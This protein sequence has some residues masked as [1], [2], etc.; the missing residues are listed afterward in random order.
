MS[1]SSQDF[2][3]FQSFDIEEIEASTTDEERSILDEGAVE[4]WTHLEIE[5]AKARPYITSTVILLWVVCTVVGLIIWM[6]T[7]NIAPF[8]SSPVLLIKPLLDILKFYYK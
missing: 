6:T 5:K 2:K 8:V 1:S 4:E 3:P 7:G